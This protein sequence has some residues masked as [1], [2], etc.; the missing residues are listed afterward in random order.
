MEGD[1]FA[2]FVR[3]DSS[4]KHVERAVQEAARDALTLLSRKLLN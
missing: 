4:S 1:R 3:G 2:I